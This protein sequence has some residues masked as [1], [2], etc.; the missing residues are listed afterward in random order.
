MS[1]FEIAII[2]I[3]LCYFCVVC[4]LIGYVRGRSR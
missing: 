4:F 2:V 3:T 1:K